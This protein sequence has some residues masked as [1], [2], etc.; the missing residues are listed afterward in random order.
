MV[1]DV[2]GSP[3]ALQPNRAHPS[4]V[5]TSDG[6][7]H[8]SPDRPDRPASA[9]RNHCLINHLRRR[10]APH[11]FSPGPPRRGGRREGPRPSHRLTWSRAKPQRY[12]AHSLPLHLC[13]RF[14]TDRCVS[15]W[16]VCGCCARRIAGSLMIVRI[17]LEKMH[18]AL[19]GGQGGQSPSQRARSTQARMP[20]RC[21]AV[22]HRESSE[23]QVPQLLPQTVKDP[24]F[25]DANGARAHR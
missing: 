15:G 2:L 16:G 23:G 17:K 8:R 6:Q 13:A 11:R 3:T 5:P 20:F 9:R 12:S 22:S 4:V 19:L 21:K 18:L 7:P 24:A 10:V 25:G 14:R 1:T